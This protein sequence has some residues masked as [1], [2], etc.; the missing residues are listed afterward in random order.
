MVL[1]VYLFLLEKPMT[2]PHLHVNWSES[3]VALSFVIVR[4]LPVELL[5]ADAA[6]SSDSFPSTMLRQTQ[7]LLLRPT[8]SISRSYA[9]TTSPHAL[10]FIEQREGVI[11]SGSLSALTAATQLGGEVTGLI[12]G[13]PGE[14]EKA[15]ESAKK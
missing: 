4:L 10:V 2:I 11:D 1:Y 7:R 13:G 5:P 6:T 12:V 15:V 3:H 8:L 14:V 9:T